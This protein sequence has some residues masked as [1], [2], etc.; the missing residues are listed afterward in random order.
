MVLAAPLN[1]GAMENLYV[2]QLQVH[3]NALRVTLA[4]AVGRVLLCT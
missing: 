3:V 2:T 4:L 1:V